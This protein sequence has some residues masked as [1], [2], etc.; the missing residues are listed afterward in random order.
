MTEFKTT[1]SDSFFERF[2]PNPCAIYDLG[3]LYAEFNAKYF[4][5]ELPVP[6]VV[7]RT[8]ENGETWHSYPRL[9]WEGRYRTKWGTYKPNNGGT[10]EIKLARHAAK[11]PLQVR[12]TLLHEMLHAYLDMKNRDDGVK[13]HGPNFIAEANRINTQCADLGVAYRINF[14]DVAITKEE[15]EVYSD[16][17]KTT[18]YCGKDLDV[19]RRL[20]SIIRAAFD[21]KYEYHQ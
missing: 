6:K 16:L 9:K 17:L 1:T 20:Q 5:G 12:S 19:A 13:G 15:P 21:T 3:E 18:I 2:C 7:S 11:D 4:N 8:D 10:G 14:Y